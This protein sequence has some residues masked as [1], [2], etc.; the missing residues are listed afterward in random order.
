VNHPDLFA[1]LLAVAAVL[2]G[3]TLSLAREGRGAPPLALAYE[4]CLRLGLGGVLAVGVLLLG[5]DQTDLLA[6]VS[7]L[8][9]AIELGW[10]LSIPSVNPQD[11]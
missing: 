10:D 8:L 11:D 9:L 2:S 1:I 5:K 6:I 3:T 4:I 7:V